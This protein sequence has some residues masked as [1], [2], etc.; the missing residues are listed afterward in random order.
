MSSIK[1][2]YQPLILVDTSVLDTSVLDGLRVVFN[3]AIVCYHAF[4][5]KN[6]FLT[7]DLNSSSFQ[8]F[9][10]NSPT[11]ILSNQGTSWV[12]IFFL[13]NSCLLVY[14]LLP[15]LMGQS[16]DSQEKKKKEKNDDD[17][18]WQIILEF[19]Y[20]KCYSILPMYI[21][22]TLMNWLLSVLIRSPFGSSLYTVHIDVIDMF[23]GGCPDRIWKNVFLINNWGP[24]IG[25]GGINWTL[26]PTLQCYILTPLLLMACRPRSDG[27]INRILLLAS[28]LFL[29]GLCI[30]I[31]FTIANNIQFPMCVLLGT[32]FWSQGLIHFYVYA[33]KYYSRSLPR[34]PVFVVGA[35]CGLLLR[36]AT[37]VTWVR[38]HRNLLGWITTLSLLLLYIH[39]SNWHTAYPTQPWSQLTS[40][41]INVVC[42]SGG[43]LHICSFA[44]LILSL[45]FQ[46]PLWNYIV[47]VLNHSWVRSLAMYSQGLHFF[48]L[49]GMY[50]AI[51]IIDCFQ[52]V[53]VFKSDTSYWLSLII[54]YA[55]V[56]AITFLLSALYLHVLE[57]F[58][59]WSGRN[60]IRMMMIAMKIRL[61]KHD[62]DDC[63]NKGMSKKKKNR[64][65]E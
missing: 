44:T 11:A 51:E 61:R 4:M 57:P 64:K 45:I 13:L 65:E 12:D 17:G 54:F 46:V 38:A 22:S 34:L 5:W 62:D 42:H 48:H 24:D 8:A 30:N 55:L 7:N 50:I 40:V 21:T 47:W 33:E 14:N 58:A 16:T 3:C 6:V 60:A 1:K 59:F 19:Y 37:A 27:F 56:L 23:I 29:I 35:L 10:N 39:M 32:S 9:V 20:K 36:S 28:V 25:C 18:L 63:N 52:W 41:F 26:A 53:D 2:E 31:Y 15:R 43:I 49:A